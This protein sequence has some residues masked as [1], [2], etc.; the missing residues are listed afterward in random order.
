M[1]DMATLFIVNDSIYRAPYFIET[2]QAAEAL[3]RGWAEFTKPRSTGCDTFHYDDNRLGGFA[4]SFALANE[5]RNIALASRHSFMTD[6]N[7]SDACPEGAYTQIYHVMS[8]APV[9]RRRLTEPRIE[10]SYQRASDPSPTFVSAQTLREFVNEEIHEENPERPAL[11]AVR[12][13][14]GAIETYHSDHLET[15]K[16]M[17]EGTRLKHVIPQIDVAIE[18]QARRQPSA[19][20]PTL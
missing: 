13:Q 1:S 5:G 7:I 9:T 19:P 17:L 8:V 4:L 6:A 3:A 14:A 18:T 20:A 2:E 16:A 11:Y 12:S 15:I 10:V